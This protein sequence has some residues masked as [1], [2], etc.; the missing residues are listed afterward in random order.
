MYFQIKINYLQIVTFSD[1]FSA[2]GEARQPVRIP[3]ESSREFS[4][5]HSCGALYEVAQEMLKTLHTLEQRL[6][7]NP[8]LYLSIETVSSQRVDTGSVCGAYVL[9]L[10]AG[11]DER[12]LTLLCNE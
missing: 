7:I 2:Y 6:A 8:S 12:A 1:F 3:Q 4:G 10:P 11:L 5:L 9:Y